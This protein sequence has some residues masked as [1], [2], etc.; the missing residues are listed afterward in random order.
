MG[1]RLGWARGRLE[2]GRGGSEW[3]ARLRAGLVDKDVNVRGSLSLKG[4]G[5]ASIGREENNSE[6]ALGDSS[7][8]TFLSFHGFLHSFPLA[9]P[10]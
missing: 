6:V 3:L 2:G 1:R 7:C 9:P 4:S 10:F 5:G 8:L